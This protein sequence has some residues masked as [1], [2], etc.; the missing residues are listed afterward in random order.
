MSE[1]FTC[2]E[3]L[4][5]VDIKIDFIGKRRMMVTERRR[6]MADLLVTNLDDK[7]REKLESMALARGMSVEET[8]KKLL[9]SLVEVPPGSSKGLGTRI[10]SLFRNVGFEE[11]EIQELR[12]CQARP[13][14]FD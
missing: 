8:A 7:I 1:Y 13:A 10:S 5:E 3:S 11:G 9:A 4:F 12:G 2:T 6:I 14:E